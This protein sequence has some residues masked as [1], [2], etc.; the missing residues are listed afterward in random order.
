MNEV[1]HDFSSTEEIDITDLGAFRREDQIPTNSFSNLLKLT[2]R[3]FIPNFLFS[4]VK[5][6]FLRITYCPGVR[7]LN[8]SIF[9]SLKELQLDTC[10]GMESLT[11]PPESSLQTFCFQGEFLR[12]KRITMNIP[13]KIMKFYRFS[14]HQTFVRSGSRVVCR[15]LEMNNENKTDVTEEQINKWIRRGGIW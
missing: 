9:P 5:L 1:V 6:I 7:N 12:L 4:S 11:I 3:N 15:F 14:I 2:I 8:T 10:Y 13:V